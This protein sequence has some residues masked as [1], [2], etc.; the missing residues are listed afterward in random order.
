MI[1][2]YTVTAGAKPEQIQAT[3]PAEAAEI[4]AEDE[5]TAKRWDGREPLAVAVDGVAYLVEARPAV[6]FFGRPA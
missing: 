4:M 5:H 2:S 6:H 3:E 1:R